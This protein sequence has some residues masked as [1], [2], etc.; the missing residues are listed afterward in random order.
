M[1]LTSDTRRASHDRSADRRRRSSSALL[2]VLLGGLGGGPRT[3]LGADASDAP[4]SAE[5][6][7]RRARRRRPRPTPTPT[8]TPSRP[9][10]P[11]LDR[12]VLR[13][14]LRPRRRDVAV[15]RQ[16]TGPRRPGRRDDPRPLLPRARPSARS[17][18]TTRIR[19]RV[20]YR[21]RATPTHA[22]RRSSAAAAPWTIDGVAATF[23]A[24]AV[25]RVIPTTT[26]GG[27]T[28]TWRI[29]VTAADGA[30]PVRR[31]EAASARRPRRDQRRPA[32]QLW[33]KPTT[34]DEY[35][36]VLRIK[37]ASTGRRS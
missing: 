14:R 1:P 34:Y 31:A 23:P 4:P 5:P 7:R 18:P 17:R 21:W 16:G 36:G 6:H 35:R 37:A 12:D 8:P 30:R 10:R 3:A 19:V 33:S 29:R 26:I 27:P 28:T 13:P 9:D 11:R 15:R 20:L 24:D 25:L 2:V 22:A 32:S